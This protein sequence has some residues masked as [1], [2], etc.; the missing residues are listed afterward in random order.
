MSEQK[1]ALDTAKML[2]AAVEKGFD[3]NIRC[4]GDGTFDVAVIKDGREVDGLSMTN[5]FQALYET[6]NAMKEMGRL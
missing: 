6:L 3:F 5:A 1:L 2:Q 4:M